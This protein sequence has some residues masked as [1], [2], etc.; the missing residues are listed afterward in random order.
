MK[1]SRLFLPVLM[2]GLVHQTAA[3]ES[4][5]D[6][7]RESI[8]SRIQSLQTEL[9][10]LRG[11]LRDDSPSAHGTDMPA[12]D[13]Q[14]PELEESVAERRMLERESERNPFAITTHRRNYLLPLSYTAR[15]SDRTLSSGQDE[16]SADRMEMQFQFSAKFELIDDQ[17][18]AN[19]DLYFGYTQ[20]SWWQAYNTDASSPFR[21]T[22]YEPEI[23]ADFD[24]DWTIAGWTN[25]HNRISLN[26]QSN[27]R[28]GDMSRSWNR[29]ILTS[30]FVN[31]TWAV[32]LAP[33]WRIPESEGDDDNP[34]IER[35]VGYG[36]VTVARR[37]F[38]DHEAS[39]MWRGNPDS[40][41]MGAQFDYSW[42]L[43]GKIRGHVLYYHGYG[44]SLIDY[45]RS[46]HRLG[47]GFS[48]NP[49]FSSGEF[50]R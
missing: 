41:H 26:H 30:T 35:F 16:A 19:G 24:N 50:E 13:H 28:S 37:L 25:I 1:P 22:N 10:Q 45:D 21:E 34:D 44:D 11:R 38:D 40:G 49:L 42:P 31:D 8:E 32:S 18:P 12:G 48:L 3:A 7:E 14:E 43:F 9:R 29:L 27:G 17:L 47:V 15:P 39:L 2:I 6:A 46:V 20:R 5:S 4:L 23:F 36:D 33:F